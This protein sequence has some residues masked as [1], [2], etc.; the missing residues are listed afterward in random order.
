M[1]PVNVIREDP[2]S[3]NILYIGTDGGAYASIDAGSS[4]MPFVKDLP[5]SIP[6]HDIAIQE[7]EN[8]IILGTHGRSLYVGKL[9]TVQKLVRKK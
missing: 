4:F 2:T 5:H 6:V 7:R 9:D 8:E 1:D 3:D